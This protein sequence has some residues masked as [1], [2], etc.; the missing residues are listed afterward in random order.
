MKSFLSYLKFPDRKTTSAPAEQLNPTD[1]QNVAPQDFDSGL[2]KKVWSRRL[3]IPSVLAV[4]TLMTTR[5]VWAYVMPSSIAYT[6]SQNGTMNISGGLTA[7]LQGSGTGLSF[8]FT[9]TTAPS[10]TVLSGVGSPQSSFYSPSIATNS[11][12]GY[13]NV[14]LVGCPNATT[15]TQTC[16]NRGTLT[17]TFNQPV[18]NP[19]I[20]L[21]GIGG[22]ATVSTQI[23]SMNS[24]F[25]L[26]SAKMVI[27]RSLLRC[28]RELGIVTSQ[29][30]EPLLR[31]RQSHLILLVVLRPI[32]QDAEL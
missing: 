21:S 9:N 26:T 22:S 24:I 10:T 17:V 25:T 11:T 20:H 5:T 23:L 31:L 6:S 19:R 16:S 4:C 13:F 1:L 29:F 32:Q 8:Y 28:H 7:T 2:G 3:I 18:K 30:L 15:T 27:F 14:G 12:A